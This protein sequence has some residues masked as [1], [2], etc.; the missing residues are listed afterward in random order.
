M[1]DGGR[2][3]LEA[4]ERLLRVLAELEAAGASGVRQ[5][6]LLRLA[7]YAAALEVPRRLLARDVGEL[8]RA[9]W[10]IIT[11]GSGSGLRYVLTACGTRVLLRFDR[12]QE[13]AL[14]RAARAARHTAGESQATGGFAD[15]VRAVGARAVL[16][17]QYRGRARQVDPA[18]VLP[19]PAGWYLVGRETGRSGDRYFAIGRMRGVAVGAA[20]SA[21]VSTVTRRGGHDPLSW[22][23]D[24]PEEVRVRAAACLADEVELALGPAMRCERVG[25]DVVLTIAVTHQAAFR[26]RL[27]G[28][29]GRV[30]VLGPDRVRASIL[31]ELS[32]LAGVP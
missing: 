3:P 15:C 9:G 23:V 17:F 20:G 13:A 29:G 32:Q 16:S 22:L 30:I 26:Q 8:N 24:P 19:G 14:L 12:A 5:D 10:E 25:D 7:G 1:S 27:Y 4:V 28:L 21:T 11:V 18:A 2:H 31:A 6:R